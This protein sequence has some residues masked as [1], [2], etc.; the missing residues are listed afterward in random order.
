VPPLLTKQF[1][2]L[3]NLLQCDVFMKILNLTLKRFHTKSK[4]CND[5]QLVK[6]LHLIGMALNEE[7]QKTEYEND[8]FKFCEKVLKQKSSDS[9][10]TH[11]KSSL[12]LISTESYKM[13][14]IWALNFLENACSKS[15]NSSSNKS[16]IDTLM[17]STSD[18]STK[19]TE[20]EDIKEK[21]KEKRKN[22]TKAKAE[23]RRLKILAQ[24][25]DMQK[26]FIK[27]NKDFFEETA[28]EAEKE[29]VSS[30]TEMDVGYVFIY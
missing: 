4:V 30:L 18:S 26:D 21:A 14:G 7:N 5:G 22:Q 3:R 28:F 2:K 12:P 20:E 23:Q 25:S 15:S 19:T 9:L 29:G 13:L 17:A 1:L 16:S 27:K 24:M 10:L 6:I 8:E 11:L